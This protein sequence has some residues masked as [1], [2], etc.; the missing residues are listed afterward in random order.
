MNNLFTVV[1]FTIKEAVKRKSFIITN[2]LLIAGIILLFNIS[3]IANLFTSNDDE[4]KK[5]VFVDYDNLIA[6]SGLTNLDEY[7][8]VIDNETKIEDLAVKVQ[9]GEY[10]GIVKIKNNNNIV[11]FD[12]IVKNFGSGLS[13]DII[14]TFVKQLVDV[15]LLLS[16]NVSLEV[17]SLIN[18][19]IDYELKKAS[20]L[21]VNIEGS[22][23]ISIGISLALFMAIYY[24]AYSI[25]TS[26]ASEKSSR[27]METLITS[28]KPSTIIL[29]K[30]I[31]MGIVGFFQILL[32]VL[33]CAISYNT[34]DGAKDMLGGFI[35]FS[36]FNIQNIILTIIY[37]ILGYILYAMLYAVVGASISR[38]EELQS[39]STPVALLTVISFYAGYFSTAFNPGGTMSVLTSFI[40]FSSPFT[41]LSRIFCESVPAMDIVISISLLIVTIVVIS[42]ISIKIYSNAVLHYGNRLK[43]KDIFKMMK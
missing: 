13:P 19:P 43:I 26:I 33:V 21:N 25:C 34:F 30:T 17:I 32:I 4:S 10:S 11:S 2:I 7:T 40:P 6:S 31:G 37:F 23:G 39:A 20:D 12:Y 35:D 15:R 42:I 28:T 9:D 16:Q 41:M 29:G 36:V 5:I 1:S 14:Q 38:Q 3:N 27:V 24:F 22:S 8:I 18:T